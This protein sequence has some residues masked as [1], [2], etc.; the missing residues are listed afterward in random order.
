[1]GYMEKYQEWIDNPFFDEE[2]RKELIAIKDDEKEIESRFYKDLEFGTAGLRGVIGAGTNRMNKYTVRKAT[3][4]LAISILKTGRDFADKG[5]V[6]AYDSRHMSKEFAFEAALTL[7]ANGIKAYV[8]DELRPTPEL[9]FAVRYLKTAAGIVITASH[10][11]KQYN[12]YKVYWDDGGQLPPKDSDRVLADI[13]SVKD[14][15]GIEIADYDES[16]DNG[17]LKIIGK[18]ID[19]AYIN[20]L[21][22]LSVN[23]DELKETAKGMKIVY[24]PFHG[25]GYKLVTRVLDETGFKNVISVPEQVAPDG[26]FPT[27]VSPNPEEKAAFKLAIELSEKVEADLTLGTD[28]DSDRV[29]VVVKNENGEYFVLEGNQT[30]LLLVD[31]IL[32]QRTAKGTM[33]KNPYCISTIVS[34]NLTEVICKHFGVEYMNVLTGFKFFGEKIHMYDDNGLK[35]YIAGFEESYGYLIGTF[36]RDKDAVVACMMIAEMAAFYKEKG[37]TLYDALQALYEKYGFFCERTIA[38]T[39]TGLEGV[40]II[41]NAM[42]TL[43]ENPPARF[44]NIDVAALRDYKTCKRKDLK[45]G[46]ITDIDSYRSDVLYFEI[47]DTDWFCIRP[48]GTEPKIKVYLGVARA[49]K[50][51]AEAARE[52]LVKNVISVID[53]LLGK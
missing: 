12:G 15:A 25:A 2:T 1:M 48:S 17:M 30:G 6:I 46:E 16:I 43:R 27:V 31:Y 35:N 23:V 41:K 50:T 39:L 52:E 22:T 14:I 38:F 47:N 44:G 24:T 29:G 53:P 51:E 11:P 3:Q 37:M 32:S 36:V 40:K 21:K 49:S 19:D 9:S 33:P 5:V 26:E 45:T 42:N 18:E 34:S 20:S 4:G 8:F 7:I 28:P 13:A 10:N